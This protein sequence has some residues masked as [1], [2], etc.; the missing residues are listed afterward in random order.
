MSQGNPDIRQTVEANRGAV[1]KLQLLIPGLRGYRSK[2]DIRVSDELLRNQV[3]D[4]LDKVKGNLDQIRKQMA[5]AGDFTNLTSVGS[6]ISQ[7][8]AL[9]GEVRHAAQGYAGFVAPIQ[10]NEDKLN[11]LYDYDY[12]FVT[13]VFQLDDATSPGNLKY[14][15]TSPNSI[16]TALGGFVQTVADIR[17]KWSLR[18]E[19]IEGIAIGQ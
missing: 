3:A 11:K 4:R 15:S 19:A 2:E 5:A 1:K 6:L 13:T 10:V 18:I 17:Q 12:A 7:V 9:S 16:Q 14:D 8:Q